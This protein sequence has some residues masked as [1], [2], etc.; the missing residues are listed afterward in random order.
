METVKVSKEELLTKL[1]ENREKHIQLFDDAMEGY[2]VEAKK[3]LNSAINKLDKKDKKPIQSIYFDVPK[4]H[5]KEYNKVIKMLEMSVSDEI[6]LKQHE[7]DMY[8]LDEWVS[9]AEKSLMT[10]YAML[11]NNSGRYTSAVDDLEDEDED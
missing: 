6:T 10:S 2:Y 4:S 5:E 1:R 3:K 11:S 9:H 7:F 8:V